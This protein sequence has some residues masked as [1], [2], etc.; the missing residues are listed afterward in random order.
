MNSFVGPFEKSLLGLLVILVAVY[1]VL[2]NCLP[3]VLYPELN[4]VRSDYSVPDNASPRQGRV[5]PAGERGVYM[6]DPAAF[7]NRDGFRKN[8]AV[9][10]FDVRRINWFAK[11]TDG[12]M[13]PSNAFFVGFRPFRTRHY[14]LPLLAVSL[15]VRYMRDDDISVDEDTWQTAPETYVRMAGDCEDHA[16][17]LADW[18]VELG[19]DARVVVGV[20]Q[21]GLHAWVQLLKDGREYLLEATDKS[22]RRRYPL[23]AFHPEYVPVF[24]F[25]R[26]HFW[27]AITENRGWRNRGATQG[28]VELSCFE[29]GAF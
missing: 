10:S 3:F 8:R 16:I 21:G 18:M 7:L 6:L 29:E 5:V 9:S 11:S 26:D 23:A 13:Y 15:R 2:D 17:L 22:S 28:W 14:W 24:M 12:Q 25:N 1:W 27:A 4:D 19:Y 20:F